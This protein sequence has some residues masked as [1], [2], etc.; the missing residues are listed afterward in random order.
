[1]RHTYEGRVF[2]GAV[3]GGGVNMTSLPLGENCGGS[4]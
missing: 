4:R 3:E 1:M 2:K